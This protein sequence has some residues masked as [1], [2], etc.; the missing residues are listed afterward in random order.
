MID[1]LH[2]FLIT[3][4][5][6]YSIAGVDLSFTNAS[7]FMLL[8]VGLIIGLFA[9]VNRSKQQIPGRLRSLVEILYTKVYVVVE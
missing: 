4:W 1:L 7:F 3:R 2:Q 9:G 6:N 8:S 5:I